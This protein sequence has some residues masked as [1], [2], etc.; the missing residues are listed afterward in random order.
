MSFS[1]NKKDSGSEGTEEKKGGEESEKWDFFVSS[2]C[3]FIAVWYFPLE[4]KI[5]YCFFNHCQQSS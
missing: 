5:N 2:F 3:L 1:K 4:K